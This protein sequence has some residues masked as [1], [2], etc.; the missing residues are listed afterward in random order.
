MHYIKPFKK[1]YGI[2][3]YEKYILRYKKDNDKRGVIIILY[4][5]I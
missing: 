1:Y 3:F 2:Y 5:W 4:I